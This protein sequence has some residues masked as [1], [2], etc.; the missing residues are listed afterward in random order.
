M[1]IK[2]TIQGVSPLLCNRF[3]E[4]AQEKVANGTT[5]ALRGSRPLPREQC[6]LAQVDEALNRL[7]LAVP[8]IKKNVLEGCVHVVGA[9]GVIQ[10]HEAELLRAMADTLDCPMPPFVA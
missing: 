3:T 10:E 5:G 4:A 2:C 1:L 6:G 8:Q 9:D 7:A